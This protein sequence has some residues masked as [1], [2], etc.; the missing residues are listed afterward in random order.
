LY[1]YPVDDLLGR[2]ALVVTESSRLP[3]LMEAYCSEIDEEEPL[4]VLRG[5]R[6]LRSLRVLRCDSII[7][8]DGAFT[9]GGG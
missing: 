1:W 2:E 3:R 8:D 7:R 4:E 9:R 5:D 6:V